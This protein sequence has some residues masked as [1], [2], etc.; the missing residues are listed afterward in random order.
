MK[1]LDFMPAEDGG[2]FA[3]HPVA[4]STRVELI[5]D[6]SRLLSRLLHPTPTGVD[7][8]EMAYARGLLA[9]M[10]DCLHFAAW[11]PGGL[12]GHLA[13]DDVRAFLDHTAARWENAGVHETPTQTRMDAMRWLWRLRPRPVRKGEGPRIVLQTSPNRLDRTDHMKARLERERAR[14]IC[15]VHDLIPITHPE[16]ARPGANAVHHA[17]MLTIVRHAR[18]II[19]NS[20]AT[21]GSL[22][23]RYGEALDQTHVRAIPLGISTPPFP[24]TPRQEPAARPYFVALGT[25][26]PR[27]NHLLLLSVWRS[28]V[29]HLGPDRTPRLLLVGRRG[30]ENEN[31]IDLLER[32]EALR[33]VVIER[34]RLPD[35]ELRQ[36][37]TG[38]RA[39]LMPSF[40]EG[41]GLP[42]AEAL[43]AGV[44]VIAS[45]LPAHREAGGAAPDYLDPLDGPAWRSAVLGY[46]GDTDTRRRDQIARMAAWSPTNWNAHLDAVLHLIDEVARC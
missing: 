18:G 25:I 11:H 5:L 7:R 34:D 8:V 43:A 3:R 45:D 30:W 24:A 2:A 21:R 13:G 46:E 27:K 19:T 38:A 32:C 4:V 29:E 17:R 9:R 12:Y 36:V 44:P 14:L 26:E 16:Y 37:I 6:L 33:G 40:V 22:L 15:M 28:L 35:A 20:E 31:V 10:P 41:F 1:R 42:I 23:A 39:L